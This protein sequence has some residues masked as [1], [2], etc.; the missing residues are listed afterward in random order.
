MR[1]ILRLA[2]LIAISILPLAIFGQ[3]SGSTA[4]ARPSGK[5]TGKNF[6][7]TKSLTG[8]VVSKSKASIVVRNSMGSVS[9]FGLSASTRAGR[10]CV[11]VGRRV[12]VTY[13]ARD[14][15]ATAVRCR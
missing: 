13:V 10:S 7:V 15:R 5:T 4:P 14:R 9:T 3:G 6:A 2:F 12:T 11:A 8:V 1:L